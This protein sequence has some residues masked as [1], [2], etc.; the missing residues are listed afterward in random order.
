MFETEPR[1]GRSL[2]G[3]GLEPFF[4]GE[5]LTMFISYICVSV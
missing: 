2:D 3:N 1:L 4:E 5:F